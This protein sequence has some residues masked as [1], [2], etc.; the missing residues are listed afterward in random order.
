[1]IVFVIGAPGKGYYDNSR[2]TQ[3]CT[4]FKLGAGKFRGSPGGVRSVS[5]G[6]NAGNA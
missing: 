2:A 5:K 1:M 6:W 3:W 4:G